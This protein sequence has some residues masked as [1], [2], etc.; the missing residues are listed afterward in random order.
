MSATTAAKSMSAS[1]SIRSACASGRTSVFRLAPVES[2]LP[3]RAVRTRAR[4]CS[5]RKGVDWPKHLPRPARLFCSP[6]RSKPSRELPDHPPRLFIWRKMRHRVAKADGPERIHGE[7]WVSDKRNHISCATTTASRPPMARATGCF[8]TRRPSRAA[9][10]GCMAWVKHELRRTSGHDAFLVPARRVLARKNCSRP[11]PL[12]GI[13]ALGIV[14]RNSL[15]GI[16]RAHEAAKVTGV[17]LIVG[18]RLDLQC[19]TSLL[20]YPTDRAAYGRLCRLLTRRQGARRQRQMSVS[21]GR[22]SKHGT[23]A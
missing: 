22:M 11:R 20:V 13:K 2:A 9:A 8:A 15:A 19:G 17:R 18:C 5:P 21:I 23:R 4:P 12:L 6:R 10:G 1:W 3:E 16:V 7:W 14:D